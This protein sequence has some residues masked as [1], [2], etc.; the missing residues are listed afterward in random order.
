MFNRKPDPTPEPM[1][2]EKIRRA[3]GARAAE[4]IE[5]FA[6]EMRAAGIPEEVIPFAASKLALR[7]DGVRML[8]HR[9]S[10]RPALEPEEVQGFLALLDDVIDRQVQRIVLDNTEQR[11]RT[12][13]LV[14]QDLLEW[15]RKR[16]AWSDRPSHAAVLAMKDADP[17]DDK[18]Q[19]VDL[20]GGK[21]T[22]EYRLREDPADIRERERIAREKAERDKR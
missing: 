19:V 12:A 21:F 18:L 20:G 4:A 22:T 1:T 6:D 9:W 17:T 8:L 13:A 14:Q 3:F 10:P 2:P 15:Q 7:L 16:D 11:A 5:H